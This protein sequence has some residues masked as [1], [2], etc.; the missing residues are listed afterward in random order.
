M[1][2]SFEAPDV[3]A[4][5][6][7]APD[8]PRADAIVL[9]NPLSEDQSVMRTT[10]VASLHAALERNVNRGASAVRIFEVG[11]VYLPSGE[12]LPDERQHLGALLWGPVRPS[13]WGDPEPP[14]AGFFAAKA[15]LH[16]LFDALR[17]EWSVTRGGE[18]FLHPG[19]T[20]T[21]LVGGEPVGW[22]GELHPRMAGDL[23]VAA[24]F[25]VDLGRVLAAADP[26][27]GYE[28]L[29]SFPSV[30]QD[31]ALV[32]PD[33]VPAADVVAVVRQAGG[34]LLRH[35]E[36]FD[37]YRERS[38]LALRLE[39]RASD[40]TLTEKEVAKRRERIVAALSERLGAQLR[41]A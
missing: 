8:D 21:V 17:V 22:L 26:V 2:W 19:R 15:V 38:S 12:Q 1:G 41:G 24:G 3:A 37:V 13:G 27:P 18:P 29:T 31:L 4:R 34:D 23:G 32:V 10:L 14:R 6:R 11:A 25:E 28:D 33:A 20:A 9:T 40:R 35:A 16:T 7:L 30:R 5:L 36:V 39:F